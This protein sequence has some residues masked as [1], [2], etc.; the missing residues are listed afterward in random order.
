MAGAA[1]N[2]T[3][4]QDGSAQLSSAGVLPRSGTAAPETG[5]SAGFCAT[6]A[7]ARQEADFCRRFEQACNTHGLTQREREILF[8]AI[9]G[10]TIDNIADR[11]SISRETVKSGL[12]RAYARAGVNGKQAFLAL[13][14]E[15]G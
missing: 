6:S 9:H 5:V 13:M 2:R 11:L 4:R 1:E 14:D 7:F 10:Y 8:T 3:V 15:Q 12:A